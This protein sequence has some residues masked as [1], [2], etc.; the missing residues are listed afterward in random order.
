MQ[1][2]KST[3]HAHVEWIELNNDGIMHECAILKTDARGNR[4]FLQINHLDNIDKGRLAQ[5]LMDRNARN[6]ELWDIMQQKT[7]GNGINAL[8][9]FH[10]YV[11][12]LT[13]NEKVLDPKSG[14]VGA[15]VQTGVFN[16]NQEK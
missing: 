12:V 5:V 13:A 1:I 14:Q 7:L 4:L 15:A 2:Q 16:I 10:Q 3:S 8:A 6:M 11:K 9:Y